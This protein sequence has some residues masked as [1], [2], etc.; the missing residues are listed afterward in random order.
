MN[1]SSVPGSGRRVSLEVSRLAVGPTTII[2][3]TI[4]VQLCN[5]IIVRMKYVST[6]WQYM[7]EQLAF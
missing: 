6:E 1:Y 4:S 2:Q 3:Y 7:T 5:K